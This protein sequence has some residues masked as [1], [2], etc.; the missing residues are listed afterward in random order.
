VTPHTTDQ[1]EAH[2]R[3]I[4]AISLAVNKTLVGSPIGDG[5]VALMQCLAYGYSRL[6]QSE[7][8]T[9]KPIMK[10]FVRELTETETPEVLQ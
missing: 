7:Q 2:N 1:E 6:D 5:I 10:E 4:H 3:R 8:R 9:L